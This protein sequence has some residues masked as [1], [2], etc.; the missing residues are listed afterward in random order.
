[1]GKIKN[2]KSFGDKKKWFER[3]REKPLK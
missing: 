3:Y 1:V 2:K